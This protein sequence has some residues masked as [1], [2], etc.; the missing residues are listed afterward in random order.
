MASALLALA[1]QASEQF[2]LLG[3]PLVDRLSAL[4]AGGLLV[5]A[6]QRVIAV[7]ERRREEK[8]DRQ[9]VIAESERSAALTL[10]E[11]IHQAHERLRNCFWSG[12]PG[13]AIA[14]MADELDVQLRR[15]AFTLTSPDVRDRVEALDA[16]LNMCL[17]VEEAD[18]GL[19]DTKAGYAIER[20]V[21]NARR[22]LV[23]YARGEPLPLPAFP[24]RSEFPRIMWMVP[25][26]ERWDTVYERLDEL[27][28]ARAAA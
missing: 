21:V 4:F 20:A 28:R 23:S 16:F 13:H 24:A 3:S 25:R 8:R 5:L 10:D 18:G 11:A 14:Q 22:S 2:V 7:R 6:L 17:A 9:A 19:D 12:D 26:A 15:E 1:A 27:Q